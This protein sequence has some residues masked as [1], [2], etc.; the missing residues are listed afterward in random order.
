MKTQQ[1]SQ[2]QQSANTQKQGR[3]YFDSL[4]YAN[5]ARIDS[6]RTVQTKGQPYTAL[7][8]TM[9]EVDDNG[10]KTYTSLEVNARG[11]KV[12]TILN[13]FR[14]EWP[15]RGGNNHWIA[16]VTIGSLK[17]SL[18]FSKKH[19]CNKPQL[20][21]RLINI[22]SLTIKGATVF[23]EQAPDQP[24][25]SVLVA[26]GYL[27]EVDMDAKH[28][29]LSFMD[30]LVT[31]PNYRK[32]QLSFADIAE[33]DELNQQ[34]LCPRGFDY[35]HEDAKIYGIFVIEN[36][37]PTLY[38]YDDEDKSSLTGVLTKVRYLKANDQVMTQKSTVQKAVD[39]FK[40]G[41]T[42]A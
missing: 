29:K 7:S 21:G 31:E 3:G 9:I 41:Y 5:Q 2:N 1:N 13:E 32:I 26:Q 12:N 14:D 35:R 8:L 39:G 20:R 33:F 40:Q 16:D 30:G 42:A 27:N 37:K 25:K 28:A 24:Q 15:T 36:V 11:D 22:K 34:G 23:G 17:D 4:L 10:K 19:S 38:Q 6:I 18:Y